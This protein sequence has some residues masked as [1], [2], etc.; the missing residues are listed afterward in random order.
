MKTTRLVQSDLPQ[1]LTTDISAVV[2]SNLNDLRRQM[3]HDHLVATKFVKQVAGGRKQLGW[4]TLSRFMVMDP[5]FRKQVE[6]ELALIVEGEGWRLFG[7]ER[8]YPPISVEKLAAKAGVSAR[9][10]REVLSTETSPTP[11]SKELSLSEALAISAATNVGLQQLLTPPWRALHNLEAYSARTVQYLP[12]QGAVT[13]DRW[14]FWIFGI[15]SLPNQNEYVFER[16]QSYPPELGDK[17][18]RQ[19][20]RINR[21][22]RPLPQEIEEFNSAIIFGKGTSWF[23]FLN[24][25][26]LLPQA[27]PLEEDQVFCDTSTGLRPYQATFLLTGLLAHLRRLIRVSRKTSG[28]R[29]LEVQWAYVCTNVTFLLGRLARSVNKR[30]G[31]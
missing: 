25:S 19:G 6:E 12:Q 4:P 2:R 3:T 20:K 13:L 1:I 24:Q 5:E 29:G 31:D 11:I 27:T 14:M 30:E 16:N 22:N 26:K 8:D 18:D 10:L 23:S 9:R 21:N 28:K 17:F 7:D 15:E